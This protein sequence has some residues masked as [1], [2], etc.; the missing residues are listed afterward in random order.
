[1]TQ[2]GE[3]VL[4]VSPQSPGVLTFEYPTKDRPSQRS[5]ALADDLGALATRD[6]RGLWDPSPDAAGAKWLGEL[7]DALE[8]R[9]VTTAEWA[10]LLTTFGKLASAKGW[11]GADGRRDLEALVRSRVGASAQARVPRSEGG[12]G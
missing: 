7:D 10:R 8:Q 9:R 11:M 1:M 6:G 2:K 12:R 3:A 4:T 5:L